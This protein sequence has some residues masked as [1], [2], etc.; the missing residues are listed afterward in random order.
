LLWC[1]W[2]THLHLEGS[3][4]SKD[5]Y[6]E[7]LRI[8]REVVGADQVDKWLAEGGEFSA[9]LEEIITEFGWGTI[10]A[11]EGLSRNTRSLLTI[12]LLAAQNRP[13]ELE[14][15]LNNAVR[16]GCSAVEIREALLHTAAY[17]GIPTARS[18]IKLA[19][20][21]LGEEAVE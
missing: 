14:V 5:R 20:K 12:V 4:V 21:V 11:R 9:P 15:H 7:G 13:D 2:L 18:A 16:N 10:W 6:Q 1:D 17:C 8:R 19:A 3:D